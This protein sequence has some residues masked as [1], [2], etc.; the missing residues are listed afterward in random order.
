MSDVLMLWI[1][2]GVLALLM[3]MMVVLSVARS[4]DG[5][6]EARRV[7]LEAK[8]DALTSRALQHSGTGW[9][10]GGVSATLAA[11]AA[12]SADAKRDSDA[13][14]PETDGRKQVKAL[15]TGL[16]IAGGVIMLIVGIITGDGS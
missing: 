6:K 11:L 4:L 1:L 12:A 3:G 14:K 2:G 9:L 13:Q 7:K 8:I 5:S 15:L 16:A 10:S